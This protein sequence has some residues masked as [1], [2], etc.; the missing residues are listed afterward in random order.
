MKNIDDR[1]GEEKQARQRWLYRSGLADFLELT[2]ARVQ[3][4][5]RRAADEKRSQH[6]DG[7]MTEAE[8]NRRP[9]RPGGY[10]PPA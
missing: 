9:T 3:R 6:N 2:E 1:D 10:P 5:P 8:K 4:A 7:R